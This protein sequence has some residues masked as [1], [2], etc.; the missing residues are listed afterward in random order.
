MKN[1]LMPLYNQLF[2]KYGHQ[3]WWPVGGTYFPGEYSI[4]RNH[5]DQFEIILGTILT[6]NTAWNNVDKALANLRNADL[7]NPEKILDS[8]ISTLETL[9]RPS[10]YFRQKAARLKEVARNY[11]EIDASSLSSEELRCSW[12][13]VNG[14]GPETA[15]SILLYAYRKPVFV[16]DNYTK[17]FCRHFGLKV[18]GKYE[19]YQKYFESRLPK[20]AWLFNEYHALIVR[21]AKENR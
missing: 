18:T 13:E 8:E 2:K 7:V 3:G 16:I 19:D 12:L 14:V 1:S 21:W 6:Q 10:G 20:E 11:L 5:K 4:P 9:I 17:R 15:D